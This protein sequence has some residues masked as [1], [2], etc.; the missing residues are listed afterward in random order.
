[1]KQ[2]TWE[3]V[4]HLGNVQNLIDDYENNEIEKSMKPKKHKLM[5]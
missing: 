5:D 2:N 4:T 1:M 3:P